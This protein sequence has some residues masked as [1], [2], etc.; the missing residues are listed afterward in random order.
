MKR[1]RFNEQGN[2]V[3]NA[4]TAN[5]MAVSPKM[6]KHRNDQS[7]LAC[8]DG[9]DMTDEELIRHNSLDI[10][11]PSYASL[12]HNVICSTISVM[13]AIRMPSMLSA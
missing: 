7:H 3:A 4:R 5:R 11:S 6:R 2:K 13:R 1:I 8:M 12:S 10:E 9:R